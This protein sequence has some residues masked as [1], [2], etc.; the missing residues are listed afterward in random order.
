[1]D[2]LLG[3]K[4]S[5]VVVEPVLPTVKAGWGH[6]R[7][8]W[9]RSWEGT[10]PGGVMTLV[11]HVCLAVKTSPDM[12][13]NLSRLQMAR[14]NS[15]LLRPRLISKVERRVLVVLLHLSLLVSMAMTVL[16]AHA[17]Q[18]HVSEARRVI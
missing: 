7:E 11:K 1:M 17:H 8:A 14:A 18:Q 15:G 16:E 4:C 3:G 9:L 13:E 12:G 5:R 10:T 2:E 6:G